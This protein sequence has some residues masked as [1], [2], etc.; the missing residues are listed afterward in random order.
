[1]SHQD[2]ENTKNTREMKIGNPLDVLRVLAGALW[3]AL[4]V[5]SRAVSA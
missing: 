2:T 3:A 4:V 1:M 5:H